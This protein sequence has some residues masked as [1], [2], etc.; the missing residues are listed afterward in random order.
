M[1]ELQPGW[2][3]SFA[4]FV[5]SGGV[6]TALT[7][8]LYLLLLQ[9]FSYRISYTAAYAAGIALAYLLYRYFVFKASGGRYGPLWVALVY[10]LQYGLGL[11][12]VWLWV[13]GFYAPAV[14]APLF[15]VAVS[16]PLTF[17]LSRWVFNTPPVANTPRNS[18]V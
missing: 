9:F 3:S 5:V 16:V 6:N 8:G 13:E 12:L 10:L 18:T 11:A 14:Y 17:V 2:K 15:A 7:Y 4:R 1:R